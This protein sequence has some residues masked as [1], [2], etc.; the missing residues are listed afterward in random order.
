MV[1]LML[2][3]QLN[4]GRRHTQYKDGLNMDAT[5]QAGHNNRAL[6]PSKP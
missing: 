4:Q 5:S 6:H 2:P 3:T 1:H